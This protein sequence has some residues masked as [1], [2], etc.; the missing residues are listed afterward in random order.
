MSAKGFNSKPI[1]ALPLYII[2]EVRKCKFKIPAKGKAIKSTLVLNQNQFEF[3]YKDQILS[4]IM[5]EFLESK[6]MNKEEN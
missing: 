1:V 6:G 3:V 2:G 5:L 4:E